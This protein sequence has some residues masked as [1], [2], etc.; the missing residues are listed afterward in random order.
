MEFLNDGVFDAQPINI[1]RIDFYPNRLILIGWAPSRRHQLTILNTGVLMDMSLSEWRKLLETAGKSFPVQNSRMTTAEL[2]AHCATS[3]LAPVSHVSLSHG[4]PCLVPTGG[5]VFAGFITL[6]GSQR[7]LSK[8]NKLCRQ[9]EE[10]PTVVASAG[11]MDQATKALG[12]R[13]HGY[14]TGLHHSLS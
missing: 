11:F 8:F 9:H 2:L 13:F 6:F 12:P 10:D 7:L 14:M 3:K 4:N 5:M 1:N